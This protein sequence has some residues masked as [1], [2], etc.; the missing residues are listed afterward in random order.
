MR[1]RWLAAARA[2]VREIGRWIAK[3]RPDAAKDVARRIRRSAQTLGQNPG[4]G[5]AGVVLDTRERVVTG[6]PY[7]I[8]YRVRDVVEIVWVVDAR[9]DW[10]ASFDLAARLGDDSAGH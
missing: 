5:R 3:D 7:I 9:R 10:P 1:V 4:L 8:I 2:D 6:L